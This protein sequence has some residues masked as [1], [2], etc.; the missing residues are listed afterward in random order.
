MICF[1]PL[2]PSQRQMVPAAP[3][4][5]VSLGPILAFANRVVVCGLGS[6]LQTVQ[7]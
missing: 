6:L 1:S 2:L 5:S 3:A 4:P 7:L